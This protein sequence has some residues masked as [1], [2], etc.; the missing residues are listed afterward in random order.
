MDASKAATAPSP[1]S[2]QK[3]LGREDREHPRPLL[4]SEMAASPDT[5]QSVSMP[6]PAEPVNIGLERQGWFPPKACH[7]PN[8]GTTYS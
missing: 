7:S 2:G 8:G 6:S 4:P 3:H 5:P 1:P